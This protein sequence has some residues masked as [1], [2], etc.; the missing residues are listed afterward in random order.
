MAWFGLL[1]LLLFYKQKA[2][3]LPAAFAFGFCWALGMAHLKLADRES[4][5]DAARRRF[6][7]HA[8]EAVADC[9][10]NVFDVI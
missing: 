7:E 10:S 6:T 9:F 5:K 2:L 1:A 4:S 3:H 8:L